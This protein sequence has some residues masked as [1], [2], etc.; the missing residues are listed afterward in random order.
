MN[1]NDL[2]SYII[3]FE[4]SNKLGIDILKQYNF[5]PIK[6][7]EIYILVA[8]VEGDNY[9]DK[10]ANIFNKP[11]KFINISQNIFDF[12]INYFAYKYDIYKLAMKS[13]SLKEQNK[14]DNSFIFQLSYKLF[15]FA[16]I[17]QASDIHIETL[18]DSLIIRFRIDGILVQ[19]FNLPYKLYPIISSILKLFASL[20]ISQKRLPQNGRFSKTIDD[21]VYDFRLS[22]LPTISGES[23]VLRVLDNKKAFLKLEDIGFSDE[24][25][26]TILK[27][28]SIP[29]GMILITGPTGSGK[30]TTLYSILNELNGK[31][32]KI[33]SIEDPI[34]Y[35]IDGI[36]QVNINNDIGLDYE[37]V[38]KNLLR[39][40]PDILMIG[41]IRDIKTLQIAIQASLTGHLVIATL[42]TNN[43]LKTI[44]RLLD[45]KAEP[46]LIASVLKLIVSQR[47]IRVLCDDCKIA[48]KIDGITTYRANGCKK[49]NLSGYIGRDIITESLEIDDK[50]ATMINQEIDIQEIFKY[51]SYTTIN[52]NSYQK[53]L[54]GVTSLEEYYRHEI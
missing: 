2:N 12:E 31:N 17:L 14:N 18:K 26:Q 3:N 1:L 32:L 10:I 4:L 9:G 16:I 52:A 19:F 44:N 36:S 37:M 13:I 8:S 43:A 45:L 29:Q 40:D 23:I 34:E 20:D 39:Q 22:T 53:V 46:F 5:F 11:I 38:L 21:D 30:T 41:E 27:N 7:Y 33:I 47:L 35:N 6:E 54:D 49:C 15:E 50:I 51:K 25:Y 48:V 28:I 24:V 42:H